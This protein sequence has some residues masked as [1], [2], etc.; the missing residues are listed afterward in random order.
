MSKVWINGKQIEAESSRKLIDVLRNDC[1]L[2][3]VKDGCSEGACGSCTVIIDG[4]A[5]KACV[6]TMGRMEGKHVLTVE[7]LTDYEKK[8]FV[9]SFGEAGAVQCGFCIPGM[10]MCAKALLDSDPQPDRI[11]IAKAIR[12]NICRCTGYKKI[13]DAISMAAAIF[14]GELVLPIESGDV[15]VGVNCHRI[16]VRDK[17]LGQGEFV[18]D[19]EIPGMIYASAVRS[20]YPR[21]RILAIH[22]EKARALPGVVTVLTAEDIPGSHVVGHLVHDWNVLISPGEVTHFLGDA[23]CLVI[24]ETESIL[25]KAKTLIHIEYE[26]LPVVLTV[27]Q[28][29]AEDAPKLH[30]NGNIVSH[31]HMVRGNVEQALAEAAFVVQKHFETPW[32]EH[33]YMEPECSIA[34]P[35]KDGVFIYSSDQGVYSIR[36][37][38]ALMLGLEQDKVIVENR[39]V[40]GGFGG[41]EDAVVQPLAALAAY[42]TGRIVKVKFT[43]KESMLVHPKRHA[44][45]I[46]L[47]LACDKEG[48]ITAMREKNLT[49]NGAYASVGGPVLQRACIHASGP[50]KF[51]N[52]DVEGIAVYTNN[53]PAGAFRGF[54]VTQTCFAIESA[55]NL[56]AEKVGISDWEIRYRNAVRPGDELPNGQI[57]DPATGIVETLLAVKDI[58]ESNQYVGIGCAIKNAG[59]GIGLPDYGR[60]RLAVEEGKIHIHSGATC[61]GQG[62]G[63]V[64]TQI[65]GETLDLDEEYLIYHY[66]NSTNAPDSGN[67]SGSRQ[68]LVTGEAARRAAELLKKALYGKKLED[69]NGQDFTGEYYAK[70]DRI[71]TDSPSPHFHVAYGYATH[72][73]VLNEDGTIKK[74]VAAHDVGKAI[75]PKS[76]EGQIEGGVVMSL[77]Y[78]LTEQYTLVNGKPTAK[79]G[80]LGLFRADKVPEVES[81][82]IEKPGVAQ[83]YGAIGIGEITSIPTAPAIQGAYYRLDG[84]FRTSLPLDDTPYA[85]KKG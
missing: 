44:F 58:Y 85:R 41:R 60:C 65:V 36:D 56:L 40:G 67:T 35:Y 59:V 28:A 25:E 74:M 34:M 52:I 70:T 84:K 6:Q 72:L 4:R 61:I 32:T 83:A 57:A 16:D 49:D 12:N 45:S 50:Y 5:V 79:F 81:I 19:M 82:I 1:H 66:P 39:L 37:E 20:P 71:G 51:K 42:R 2:K 24:A 26:E 17:V 64:L 3:S 10:V 55:L 27:E 21:A 22:T 33:A 78:A 15:H 30:E 29:L 76:V 9:Y 63:T 62:L 48:H 69:L 14:R 43:R 11:Q 54:G 77:G 68:T 53:P 31:Q 47:T 80:T 23:I 18:D 75:N 38:C 46:D 7:G 8:V 13:I 73:C